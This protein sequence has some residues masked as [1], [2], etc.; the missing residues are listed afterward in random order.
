MR[1]LRSARVSVLIALLLLLLALPSL[2]GCACGPF[3]IGVGML[4]AR[5]TPPPPMPTT[6]TTDTGTPAATTPAATVMLT[7]SAP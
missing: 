7:P 6:T 5:C 2:L 1:L 3:V 4:P